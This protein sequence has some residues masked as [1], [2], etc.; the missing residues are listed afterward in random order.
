MDVLSSVEDR[1]SEVQAEACGS[2]GEGL[3]QDQADDLTGITR[4]LLVGLWTSSKSNSSL[5]MAATLF[6]TSSPGCND[7]FSS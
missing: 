2:P 6:H 1:C 7:T 4:K 3:G 5:T